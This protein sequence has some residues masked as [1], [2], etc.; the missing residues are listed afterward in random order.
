MID[1][2]NLVRP[3]AL[4]AGDRVAAVSLSWGGPGAFRQRYEAGKRQL[5]AE[6]GVEV[7][8]MPHT[9]GRPEELAARPASRAEDL[10]RALT[11]P[12]IA[13]IISTIGGDDSIRLLPLL[14][15]DLMRANPKVFLG[16]SDTTIT[17]MAFL[18]AGVVSFY[19][20]SLMTGF[21]EN[22]GMHP[23]TRDGVREL[24]FS[25]AEAPSWPENDDGWTVEHLDWSDPSNQNRRR[26]LVPT[27]GWRWLGGVGAQGPLVAGCME[28][29][30]WLRG[31]P[32][33]PDLD[34]AVLA[35]ETSEEGPPPA[36]VTRFLR[37]LAAGGQLARLAAV[38]FGRPGGWHVPVEE[39]LAY[40]DA[41][42]DVIR[43]EAGMTS[44]PIVTGMDFGH[45]DPVW[46]LPLGVRIR[47][48]PSDRSIR[49]LEPGV[50]RP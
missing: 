49:F 2:D 46:T 17:Q 8:A 44:V 25:H 42:V 27:S 30:D 32:W 24:L 5:E 40:D 45:T 43:G 34:G 23:Y 21:A 20:P 9:L 11:D 26:A 1:S 22:G 6:F 37:S 38:L 47:V 10:H 18:R 14:D 31:T 33:L 50:V 36:I 35:I 4:T 28:V 15:L 12:A 29:L 19:G 3:R 41:I 13:G 48:D 39:H 16:F 7:V